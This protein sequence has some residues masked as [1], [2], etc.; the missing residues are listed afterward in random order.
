[1]AQFVFVKLSKLDMGLH[2][3]TSLCWLVVHTKV[4]MIKGVSDY[5]VSKLV[6]HHLSKIEGM[7]GTCI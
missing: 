7:E 3:C 6:S 4:D 2:C 1:M 5:E